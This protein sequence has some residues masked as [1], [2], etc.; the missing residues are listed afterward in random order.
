MSTR[1]LDAWTVGLAALLLVLLLP[2]ALAAVRSLPSSF[3]SQFRRELRS[4]AP[5]PSTPVLTDA[6]LAPLPAVVRAYVRYT[7]AVGKPRVT[8]FRLRFRG[9]MIA[10]PGGSPMSFEAEQVSRVHPASRSFIMHA[11]R[12]GVPFVAFH[13]YAGST[14][15][16]EVKV[17]DLFR[18]I[19][20]RGPEMDQSETVTFF[21]DLC[22]FAPGALPFAPVTWEE[23]APDRV[24]ATFE[25]AGHRISAVL[26]FDRQQRLVN[27]HSDHRYQ[28]SDGKTFHLYRWS[29]PLADYRDYGGIRIAARG[30]AT[31]HM[32]E[33]EL[34]YGR[35]DLVEL[36]YNG[37]GEGP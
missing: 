4:T 35:F 16:M 14:A 28:S 13:H 3:D 22:V 9:T 19:Y 7:G 32:P 33:G 24:K 2:V 11:R 15:T 27:F 31:W 34:V 36:R 10:T 6:D 29:T 8:S 17:A 12:F 30:D 21:N 18:I 37:V 5:E 20:A 26:Y 1:G 25:N 23:L